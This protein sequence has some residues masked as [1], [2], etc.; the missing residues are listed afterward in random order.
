MGWKAVKERY[1]I[2]HVVHRVGDCI[3]I[4]S[5]YVSKIIAIGPD[6]TLRERG[7]RSGG[8]GGNA[9]LVRYVAEFDSD[10]EALRRA[11]EAEDTFSASIPVFTYDGS[12]IV[13]KRCEVPGW[14]HVTHDGQIMY[15]N[16]HFVDRDKA[17]A[18]AKSNAAAAV[19]LLLERVA[20]DRAALASRETQLLKAIAVAIELGVPIPDSPVIHEDSTMNRCGAAWAVNEMP[21]GPTA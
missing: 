10:P 20:S 17:V 14:P 12:N 1:R 4:G 6:G 8:I 9:N 7:E 3:W 21:E 13:E 16:T 11:V 15:D 2:E 19:E 18:R 5:G